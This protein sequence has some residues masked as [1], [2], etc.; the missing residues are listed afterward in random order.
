[1]HMGIGWNNF[2]N[3]GAIVVSV[4]IQMIASDFDYV[5]IFLST[6]LNFYLKNLFALQDIY[7]ELVN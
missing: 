5:P 2:P 1:M 6:L 7:P 3:G 4:L